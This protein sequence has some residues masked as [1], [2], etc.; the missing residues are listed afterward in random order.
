MNG[1]TVWISLLLIIGFFIVIAG[2]VSVSAEL[3]EF[4]REVKYT[5]FWDRNASSKKDEMNILN[6]E[7]L[8]EKSEDWHIIGYV[9]PK[10]MALYIQANCNPAKM[11][12]DS[13]WQ[14]ILRANE[15]GID[16]IIH[17]MRQD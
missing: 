15:V 8:S 11:S 6:I 3:S 13:A 16:V 10:F 2:L 4:H 17:G 1:Q 12:N 5:K 14:L 7:R 9:Q